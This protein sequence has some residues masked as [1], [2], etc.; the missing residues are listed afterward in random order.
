VT[1]TPCHHR[2]PAPNSLRILPCELEWPCSAHVPQPG[3]NGAPNLNV[4]PFFIYHVFANPLVDPGPLQLER[5]IHGA[6]VEYEVL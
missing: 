5:Q 1:T 2:V 6:T 3:V 4:T